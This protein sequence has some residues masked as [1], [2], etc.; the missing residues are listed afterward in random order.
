MTSA[1]IG[2]NPSSVA[3]VCE[4]NILKHYVVHIVWLRRIL[5]Y[6]TDYH[7]TRFM[8]DDVADMDI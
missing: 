6:A 7:S 5:A 1:C 4:I 2:L 8:A 3:A